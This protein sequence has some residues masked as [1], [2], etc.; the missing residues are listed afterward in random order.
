LKGKTVKVRGSENKCERC[1]FYPLA[2][3]AVKMLVLRGFIIL[4][5]TRNFWMLNYF[6]KVLESNSYVIFHFESIS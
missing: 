4:L 6:M 5:I 1:L 2:F 3:P